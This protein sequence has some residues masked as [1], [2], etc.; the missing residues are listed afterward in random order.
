[1]P[2]GH[3]AL[4]HRADISRRPVEE[5]KAAMADNSKHYEDI[6]K[7]TKVDEAAADKIVKYLG[8]ALRNRDSAYVAATD[9]SELETVR[10]SWLKKKLGLS[11][12]DKLD[13]GIAEVMEAMKAD[14]MKGR[15][16]VYYLLAEKFGKL[17]SL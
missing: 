17:G 1:M 13:A 5:G 14:R 15:A 8:I 12:D 6:A 16:T 4:K 2:Y 10:E 9:P 7:Y 3:P 11:G